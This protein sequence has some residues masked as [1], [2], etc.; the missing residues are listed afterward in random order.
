[1]GARCLQGFPSAIAGFPRRT[2]TQHLVGLGEIK[3]LPIGPYETSQMWYAPNRLGY[4]TLGMFSWGHGQGQSGKRWLL[5]TRVM[6]KPGHLSC[7]A[8]FHM[9]PMIMAPS[10]RKLETGSDCGPHFWCYTVLSALCFV[11][12]K[13]HKIS[14]TVNF[15]EPSHLKGVPDGMFGEVQAMEQKLQ[16]AE[17]ISNLDHLATALQKSF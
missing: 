5:L 10:T 14:T 9:L 13:Q 8:L 7:A 3:S 16:R 11:I 2:H 4:N 12:P 1:M 6:E 17:T 15:G